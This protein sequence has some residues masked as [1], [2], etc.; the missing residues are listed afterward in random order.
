M[1]KTFGIGDTHIGHANI[2]KFE[3]IHRPFK[4]IEE[5][6]EEIIKRWNA[7]VSP[8]DT[9]WHLGDVLFGRGNFHKLE[10]LNGIKN[11]IL[12][13]HD[14]YGLDLYLK[15]FNKVV[16]YHSIN[17]VLLSHMPV[18]PCQ[19]DRYR[20]NI[21]GHMHSKKVDD[22]RYANLS[23]EHINL[24]PVLLDAIINKMPPQ[25]PK[26]REENATSRR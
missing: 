20:G 4:T 13:N 3:P 17:G 26:P 9:V 19:L 5:H 11:L 12:G 8:K 21:H 14:S 25:P 10:R 7:T 16:P 23:V 6:D 1:N 18:H 24:T 15:Y 22:P 2:L